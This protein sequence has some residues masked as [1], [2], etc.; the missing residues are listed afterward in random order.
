MLEVE[1]NWWILFER[2]FP[3]KEFRRDTQESNSN[4]DKL[5]QNVSETRIIPKSEFTKE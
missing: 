3:E 2:H 1:L 4:Y 5:K